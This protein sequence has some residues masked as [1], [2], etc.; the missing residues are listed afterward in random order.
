MRKALD[1]SDHADFITAL[2]RAY[3]FGHA[4]ECEGAEEWTGRKLCRRVRGVG[5]IPAHSQALKA[6]YT[7]GRRNT[8]EKKCSER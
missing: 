6:A 7:A 3:E 8:K 4:D 2:A 1:L 5:T